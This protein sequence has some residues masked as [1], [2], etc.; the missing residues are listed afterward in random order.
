M[1][2]D[3]IIKKDGNCNMKLIELKCKNCGAILEVNEDEKNIKC[4]YCRAVFKLDD[5]VQHVQYDNMR[6][7]G[8]EFEKGRIQ[9]QNEEKEKI[10][11][12]I[13]LNEQQK[14]EQEKKKKNLK[15]WIIGWIFCFPIP[16][17]I[18]IWRSKW[19]RNRK[20]IVTAV[21]WVILI[22]IGWANQ[23]STDKFSSEGATSLNNYGIC[24]YID[25][26]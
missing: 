26:S 15:W 16:I 9:A 4:K 17:T 21:M 8:Y 7:S 13:R 19:D 18:L 23:T 6:E 22:L 3:I 10:N 1:F 14:I 11:E 12:R 5:D 25:I 20:I 2:Y 24:R